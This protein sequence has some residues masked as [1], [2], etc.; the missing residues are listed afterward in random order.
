MILIREEKLMSA[1]FISFAVRGD[2]AAGNPPGP[3]DHIAA[4][5]AFTSSFE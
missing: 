3:K 4:A 5:S 2:G 1:Y